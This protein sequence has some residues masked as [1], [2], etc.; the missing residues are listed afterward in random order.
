[1]K[2]L[3]INRVSRI[4]E[5]LPRPKHDEF[6]KRWNVFK[7]DP[8]NA[9]SFLSGVERKLH[10]EPL[11]DNDNALSS[12]NQSCISQNLLPGNPNE[13]LPQWYNV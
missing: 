1:M 13:S 9:E 7:D 5:I 12:R 4:Q 8:G 11:I 3:M 10:I 6:L 2:R